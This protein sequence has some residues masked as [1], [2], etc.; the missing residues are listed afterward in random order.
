M[1]IVLGDGRLSIQR[2]PDGFYDL[3]ILD[4]YNSDSLPAHLLSREALKLYLRKLSPEGILLFHISNRYLDIEPVLANLAHDAGLYCAVQND[5]AV[6]VPGLDMG[7]LSSKYAIMVQSIDDLGPLYFDSRWTP[8]KRLDSV[9]VWTDSY[10][11][12]IAILKW[13]R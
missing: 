8:A 12:I 2:A 10:S 11:S 13:R 9:G 6:S 7:K 4:A 1:N 3:F 5:K